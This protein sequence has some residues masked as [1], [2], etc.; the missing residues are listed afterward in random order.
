LDV[1]RR[2]IEVHQDTGKRRLWTYAPRAN[3]SWFADEVDAAGCNALSPQI[4]QAAGLGYEKDVGEMIGEN[5]I[6][7]SGMGWIKPNAGQPQHAHQ[8]PRGSIVH[9]KFAAARA[10]A[11]VEFTYP[12][13]SGHPGAVRS[14]LVSNLRRISAVWASME[15]PPTP[16]D[17]RPGQLQVGEEFIDMAS[18]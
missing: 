10:H 16:D 6:C 1:E 17:V 8:R 4:F 15:P 9:G 5:A 11:M 18:S 2:A 7:S 14:R 12:Q 3:Q 13:Q